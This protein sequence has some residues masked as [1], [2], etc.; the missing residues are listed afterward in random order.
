MSTDEGQPATLNQE[1]VF[2]RVYQWFGFRGFSC[3]NLLYD[4][5]S[6]A[7]PL[8]QMRHLTHQATYGTAVISTLRGSRCPWNVKQVLLGLRRAGGRG[9]GV[10]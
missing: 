5:R 4:R 7:N 9:I 1:S 3:L 2:T 10:S 6:T 8:H